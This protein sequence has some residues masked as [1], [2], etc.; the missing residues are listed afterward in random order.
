MTLVPRHSRGRGRVQTFAAPAFPVLSRIVQI[1]CQPGPLAFPHLSSHSLFRFVL[2]LH[3]YVWLWFVLPGTAKEVTKDVYSCRAGRP[4]DF[5]ELQL[6]R[7]R[8]RPRADSSPG[9][10]RSR[11]NQRQPKYN[12][13]VT[14]HSTSTIRQ[15]C[16]QPT[17][18]PATVGPA[19]PFDFKLTK[20]HLH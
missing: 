2:K 19:E 3:K 18:Q 1:C 7:L 16:I 10:S 17:R 6:L 5:S 8:L 4:A 9:Q 15:P 13:I 20:L 11:L 14:T 12:L